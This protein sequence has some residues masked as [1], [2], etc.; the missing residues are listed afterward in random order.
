MVRAQVVVPFTKVHLA[1]IPCE[2]G[3]SGKV[4]PYGGKPLSH[5]DDPV[6]A[7]PWDDKLR[8]RLGAQSEADQVTM[9]FDFGQ[10]LV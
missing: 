5:S 2:I 7:M 9:K 6:L 3:S 10:D 1:D 8:T 4:R